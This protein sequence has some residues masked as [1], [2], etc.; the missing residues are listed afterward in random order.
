MS[1]DY[2]DRIASKENIL[3]AWRKV[4]SYHSKDVVIRDDLAISSVE[5]DLD[6]TLYE[7]SKKLRKGKYV[8]GPAKL[9]CQPKSQQDSDALTFRPFFAIPVCDQI[10]WIAVVN[11]IGPF[12]D[13]KMPAWSYGNRLYRTSWIEE[14]D[15][16][17]ALK[18]GA[19]RNSLGKL[20]RDFSK[21]WP[22][23]RRHI[24]LTVR[25]M[26]RVK[27]GYELDYSESLLEEQESNRKHGKLRYLTSGFWRRRSNS[28]YWAAIDFQV[29]STH[30]KRICQEE[31][32]EVLT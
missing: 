25:A 24:S 28:I 13:S 21:S 8:N 3:W 18:L 31:Y 27:S 32:R 14:E 23:F 7:I 16:I 15:N 17:R 26:A 20:Y 9:I 6:N 19:Y 12:L 22:L 1:A 10:A 29:L 30:Q 11:V 5:S 4:K 2:L